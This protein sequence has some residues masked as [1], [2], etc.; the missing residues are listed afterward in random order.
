MEKPLYE[1]H[2]FICT[3]GQPDQEG[4][5]AHKGSQELQQAVK[6]ACKKWGP[7]VRVNKSGC[8]GACEKGIAAVLYP[9]KMAWTELKSHDVSLLEQAIADAFHDH[10]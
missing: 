10:A 9:Q 7:R 1:A 2:L 5:C 3:N 4:K 8:L 6:G